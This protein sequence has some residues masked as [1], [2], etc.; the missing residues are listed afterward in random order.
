MGMDIKKI[1]IN[2]WN[3]SDP[4]NTLKYAN[5]ELSKYPEK[6]EYVGPYL[7]WEG[8]TLFVDLCFDPEHIH[9]IDKVN[10]KYK[11]AWFH[12][13]RGLNNLQPK[14]LNTLETIIDKFD[15]IMTY[16]EYL[17][18]KYPDKCKFCIDNGIWVS[19]H[20]IKLHEKT[21]LA[22]MIYSWK[23][24][25][26]GH[27]IRH[28]VANLVQGLDLYGSGPNNPINF[29]E[30]GLKDYYFSI[31]IENSKSKNYFTE[32]ILDCFACGTIPIYWGCPNIGDYFDAR[33]IIMFDSIK[34][35]ENIFKKMGDINYINSF[36]PYIKTNFE[37]V[38]EY[39]RYEDWIYKNIYKNII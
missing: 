11:V 38:K 19:D 21:K 13:P 28:Q 27:K 1:K 24:W 4:N 34:D 14:R 26:P 15:F 10:S 18:D 31:T 9:I 5:H 2:A 35:L 17:L 16:D 33:G 32:K 23:N 12:E 6:V 36:K 30:E 22:S 25:S 20:M 37:K 39:S 29:K 8:I 3:G 7:N